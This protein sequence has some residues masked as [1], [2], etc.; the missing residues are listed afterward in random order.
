MIFTNVKSIIIPEGKVTQIASGNTIIWKS[1][2]SSGPSGPA[3]TN[4]LPLATDTDR[5]TIY[6]GCGYIT[7]K[8]LS[9]SGSV[10][11][12]TGMCASGFIP[13]KEG[14]ILRIKGTTPK[15]GTSSYVITYNSSN[16]KVAHK[17][18]YQNSVPEWVNSSSYPWQSYADGVLTITLDSNFGT[19]FDAIRFS[20]GVINSDTIVTINQEITD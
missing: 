3:Y 4:L 16:E 19:G 2:E 8:R 5:K 9:S 17:A 7:G 20:A 14:D 13:A 10:S 18:L 1:S 11:T 12:A 15:T 6:N